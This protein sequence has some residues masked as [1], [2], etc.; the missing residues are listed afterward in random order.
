MAENLL[1]LLRIA[2][3]PTSLLMFKRLPAQFTKSFFLCL[4]VCQVGG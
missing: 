3:F 2:V 4:S 1:C